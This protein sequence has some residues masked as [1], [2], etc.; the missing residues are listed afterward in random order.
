M[1]KSLLNAIKSVGVLVAI[2][3]VCV[4]LL[5]VCNMFFPKYVSRLD[6]ETAQKINSI[7]KAC[8]SDEKAFTDGYIVM[9]YEDE[10]GASLSAFNK[11]NKSRKAEILAVYGE[12]KGLLT[13]AFII[14]SSAQGRDSEIVILTAYKDGVII[15]ATVKKQNES[16]FSKL[17]ED[18]FGTVIGKNGEVNLKADF[19]KTGATVSLTAINR[20]IN[21]S[22]AFAADYGDKI[23]EAISLRSK[24]EIAG[25]VEKIETGVSRD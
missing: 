15:G 1:T 10:Y 25:S 17:P 22:N 14:E 8:D 2:T 5:T 4:G 13:G 7:A 18:L 20:A 11:D 12:P 23:R 21:M 16:Y 19:G 3:V 6:A 9:L 24:A